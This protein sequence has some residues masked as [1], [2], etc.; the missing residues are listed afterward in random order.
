MSA[1]TT[2]PTS[3][4][5]GDGLTAAIRQEHEAASTAVRPAEDAL[6]RIHREFKAACEALGYDVDGNRAAV[7]ATLD[8]RRKAGASA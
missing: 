8:S 5:L 4:G 6:R 3:T 1:I 7:W 2:T